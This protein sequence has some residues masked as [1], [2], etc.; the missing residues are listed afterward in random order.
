MARVESGIGVL[1]R[2]LTCLQE[3]VMAVYGYTRVSTDRQADDG[4]SL[5]TQ[6]RVIGRYAMISSSMASVNML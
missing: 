5:G 6:Q 3:Q 1:R 2:K 4:E